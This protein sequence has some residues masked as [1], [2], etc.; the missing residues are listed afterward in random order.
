MT[1]SFLKIIIFS[2]LFL[3][4][5]SVSYSQ[6]D[7]KPGD[8]TDVKTDVKKDSHEGIK[9]SDGILYGKDYDQS[10]S[11]I[12]FDDLMKNAE[13][14]NGKVVVVKGDVSEVCQ[15]MGCWMTMTDGTNTVRVKTLHEFFL[16]KDIAGRNAVVVGTFN[17]TEI[18]EDDAKHYNE[19]SSNPKNSD[20][21]KGTQKGFEI[22]ANGVKILEAA[23]T[24][25]SK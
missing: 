3:L 10:M 11:V 1:K 5:A 23:A 24:E 2:F 14:H 25:S 18:S 20:E 19:E 13:Q 15:K 16:P 9:M 17:I 8:Q 6:D 7:T 4:A 12:T 22:D 21:I